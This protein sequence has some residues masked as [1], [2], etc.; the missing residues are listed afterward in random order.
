LAPHRRV[1]TC[2]LGHRRLKSMERFKVVPRTPRHAHFNSAHIF[3]PQAVSTA[4]ATRARTRIKSMNEKSQPSTSQRDLAKHLGISHVTVSLAM[5]DH[6]RI[7]LE[8]RAKVKQAAVD[9]GYRPDPMLQSLARYRKNKTSKSVHS[10]IAWINASQPAARFHKYKEFNLYWTSAQAAAATFGY[11]LEEFLL[12]G[13]MTPERL[14]K[15]LATRGIP[16]ILLPPQFPH[17]DW[18]D[19]PWDYYS[20]V[21]FGRSLQTPVCNVVTSDHMS[22]AMLAFR[23]IRD[24]G[25]RRIGF[26]SNEDALLQGRHLFEI[27][28]LAAQRFVPAAERIPS[29]IVKKASMQENARQVGQWVR[30]YRVDAIFTDHAALP[31]ILENAGISVPGDVGLAVTTLLDAPATAGI[32][33]HSEEIGRDAVSHLCS[34]IA[35]RSTGVPEISRETLVRGTWVNGPSMPRRNS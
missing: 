10:C 7:S 24:L 35:S 28:F 30:K 4:N 17:P 23:E 33:Q 21:R 14:H 31:E 19:F 26:V 9:L 13:K 32:D 20:I 2:N 25:Y 16:G 6:P 29:C 1:N 15:I 34:L 8:T 27:G 5:R 18:Q 22:N 3:A 11:R 12:G